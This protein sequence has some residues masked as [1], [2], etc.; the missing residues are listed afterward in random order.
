MTD[1]VETITITVKEYKQLLADQ[2][3]LDALHAGGVDNW[4]WYSESLRYAGLLEDDEDE[5]DE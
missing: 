4:D 3:E 2:R 5:E 1:L